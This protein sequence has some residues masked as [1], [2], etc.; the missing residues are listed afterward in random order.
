MIELAH[1]LDAIRILGPD[2]DPVRTH[3]VVDRGALFEELRI[4]DDIEGGI[5]AT[6]IEF[7]LNRIPNHVGSA[8]RY[9]RFV[10]NEGRFREVGSDRARHGLDMSE[11]R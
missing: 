1:E 4:A 7:L 5:D 6:A 2:H 3:E 9:G 8:H 10:D 11:V